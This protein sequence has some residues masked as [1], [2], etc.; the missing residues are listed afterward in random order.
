MACLQRC[1]PVLKGLFLICLMS[2]Y[3][4]SIMGDNFAWGWVNSVRMSTSIPA[5][6][7]VLV[8]YRPEATFSDITNTYKNLGLN[9]VSYSPYNGFRTVRVSA[10]ISLDAVTANLNLNPVVAYAEPNYLRAVHFSPNDPLYKYQWHLNNPMMERA[11]D[12][13]I[14]ANVIVAILD[15]GVAYRTGGG[16]VQAPD[17]ADT[18]FIP[19]Y[20]FINDDSYPDDDNRHGT[21]IAGTIAQSTNNLYGGAG[22]APGCTIMPVKVLDETGYGGV[23]SI[24]DGIYYA[25]NNGAQIINMSLGGN[26]PPGKGAGKKS[27]AEEE[28]INYAVSQGVTVICSAGNESSDLPSYPASYDATISVSAT[29]YDLSFASAYSNFGPT[30]DICA[31]GGDLDEDLNGDGYP[32]GIYQQTHDGIDYKSFDYYFAEGTSSSS[33]FV[34]GVA[35]LIIAYANHLITPAEMREILHGTAIDLGDPGWDQFYGWGLVNPLEALQ[36]VVIPS[37]EG[38]FLPLTSK[39]LINQPVALINNSLQVT[40]DAINR[41]SFQANA[42][43]VASGQRTVT[44]NQP[45]FL[46]SIS[47]YQSQINLWPLTNG[48]RN[49]LVNGLFVNPYSLLP[50]PLSNYTYPVTQTSLTNNLFAGSFGGYKTETTGNIVSVSDLT[51]PSSIRGFYSLNSPYVSLPLYLFF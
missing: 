20:D 35:A 31:P 49:P 43:F 24:V 26:R 16:Y 4:Q 50:Y 9:E 33:A 51:Y 22:V 11:W 14:G 13:S 10:N 28:A 1:G 36:A 42:N 41:V 25:V 30:I 18:I 3:F 6:Q 23:D 19:G 2:I 39:P 29:T 34:S 15:S 8:Q 44:N 27:A 40:A 12:L 45:L 48:I 17:L 21:H 38:Y 47:P 37:I 7:E 5:S 32:D 46:Q